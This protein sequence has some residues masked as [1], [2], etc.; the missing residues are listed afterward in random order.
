MR[1][2]VSEKKRVRV[3][4]VSR[5]RIFDGHVLKVSAYAV[6]VMALA[7][8]IITA[9]IALLFSYFHSVDY[10]LVLWT[11]LPGAVLG[12]VLLVME[13]MLVRMKE[14]L[15][16]QIGKTL[17]AFLLFFI[18]SIGYLALSSIMVSYPL[19]YVM[20]M[21]WSL[22]GMAGQYSL[23][24]VNFFIILAILSWLRNM[25]AFPCRCL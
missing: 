7:Y 10:R 15:L 4:R 25:R 8:V 20:E 19:G 23:F 12:S 13:R 9:A 18:H 6:S 2:D 1:S 11:L 21:F 17:T 14:Y 5:A 22:P 3:R 16:P 24:S